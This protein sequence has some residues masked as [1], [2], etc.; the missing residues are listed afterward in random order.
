MNLVMVVHNKFKGLSGLRLNPLQ[1][2]RREDR[3]RSQFLPFSD[4]LGPVRLLEVDSLMEG[5]QDVL[6][7]GFE[8][9]LQHDTP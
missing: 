1:G 2:F 5:I 7:S 9:E 8:A 4:S 3:H 6:I